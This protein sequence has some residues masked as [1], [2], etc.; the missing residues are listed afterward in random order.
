MFPPMHAEQRRYFLLR[1]PSKEPAATLTH[2][3]TP[4][5]AQKGLA[6]TTQGGTTLGTPRSLGQLGLV[7]FGVGGMGRTSKRDS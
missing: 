3:V 6:A 2:H 4:A 7:W 5:D 1:M